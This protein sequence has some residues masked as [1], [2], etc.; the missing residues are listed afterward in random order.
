MRALATRLLPVVSLTTLVALASPAAAGS[1]VSL[2]LGGDPALQGELRTA[3]DGDAGGNGRLALGQRFG[4]VAVEASL[5]RFGL[6]DSSATAAG[7]HARLSFPLGG[8][9]EAYGR[10][11][12]ERL[13]LGDTQMS[14]GGDAS[15]LV[16]GAGLEFRVKAPLIGAASIWA[17]L[18]QDRFE[19]EGGASGGVRLWTLGATIGL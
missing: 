1:Y 5:S 2:G 18:S 7:I 16:G 19:T 15:G 9:F 8:R 14:V 10:L 11:G 4:R 12:L 3:A 13:W 6:V 17:E